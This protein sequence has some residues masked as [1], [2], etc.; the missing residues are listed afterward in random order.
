LAKANHK[1]SSDLKIGRKDSH[2]LMG[3]GATKG[4][5]HEVLFMRT[6]AVF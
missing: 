5:D 4:M 6:D 1:A 3:V 2:L